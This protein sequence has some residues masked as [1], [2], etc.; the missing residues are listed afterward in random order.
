MTSVPSVAAVI[1]LIRPILAI[2]TPVAL[3]SAEEFSREREVFDRGGQCVLRLLPGSG[4]RNLVLEVQRDRPLELRF[5]DRL[6]HPRPIDR[7]FAHRAVADHPPLGRL[8][9]V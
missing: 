8:L 5:V 3:A 2:S 1:S 6:A 7:A 4:T 9:P